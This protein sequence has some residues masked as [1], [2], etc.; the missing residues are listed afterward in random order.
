MVAYLFFMGCLTSSIYLKEYAVSGMTLAAMLMAYFYGGIL[1]KIEAFHKAKISAEKDEE[2]ADELMHHMW[3][4][5]NLE[6]KY[7]NGIIEYFT[8]ETFFD[9]TSYYRNFTCSEVIDIEGTDWTFIKY[10]PYN[11][12]GLWIPIFVRGTDLFTVTNDKDV[13]KAINRLKAWPTYKEEQ[14]KHEGLDAADLIEDD[15]EYVSEFIVK[16]Y[17]KR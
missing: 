7:T 15:L 3:N 9:F 13:E 8:K 14:D 16:Q 4:N 11:H 12:P 10:C 17:R 1:G 2:F 5:E 6:S